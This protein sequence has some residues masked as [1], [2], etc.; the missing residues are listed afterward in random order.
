L[1]SYYY[2]TWVGVSPMLVA[3]RSRSGADR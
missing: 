3:S 2:Y 1:L